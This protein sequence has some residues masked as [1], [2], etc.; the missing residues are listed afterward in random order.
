MRRQLLSNIIIL[1]FIA[2]VVLLSG[3]SS[4]KNIEVKDSSSLHVSRKEF[5]ENLQSSIS[6][7]SDTVESYYAKK[8]SVASDGIPMY[9]SLNATL[10]FTD[11]KLVSKF[12]LPFPVVEVA[13]VRFEE[14]IFSLY[15]KPLNKNISKALPA[16]LLTVF[17]SAFI[18]VV[19]PVYKY[20]GDSDFSKFRIYVEL[21]RFVMQRSNG[22]Y[23]VKIS[24]NADYTLHS[25]DIDNGVMEL[26]FESSE[27]GMES[28]INV[29]HF[30]TL[31]SNAQNNDLKADLTIK[32]IKLNSSTQLQY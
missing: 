23:N 12:Y 25:I 16:E 29:P 26:S 14:G 7:K 11:A 21:D 20:L 15:S 18:G 22:S 24:V 3:C 31:R 4:S 9:N 5:L 17:K 30:I 10:Y 8:I 13:K 19:P 6:Q 28:G 32:S 1:S 27:Y 2:T